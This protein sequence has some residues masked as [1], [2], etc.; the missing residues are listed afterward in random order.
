[1]RNIFAR[2]PEKEMEANARII[3]GIS[4]HNFTFTYTW[5]GPEDGV[6][7]FSVGDHRRNPKLW[8]QVQNALGLSLEAMTPERTT[9]YFRRTPPALMHVTIPIAQV[10]DPSIFALTVELAVQ[11][12]KRSTSQLKQLLTREDL[13]PLARKIAQNEIDSR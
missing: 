5:A 12:T 11:L 7:A 9:L 3:E 13:D 4:P 8:D 10:V 6:C 2:I 1:M